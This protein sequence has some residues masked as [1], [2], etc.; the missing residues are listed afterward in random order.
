MKKYKAKKDFKKGESVFMKDLEPSFWDE[1]SLV[2]SLIEYVDLCH[3]DEVL[4]IIRE[5][6]KSKFEQS[7][8][9]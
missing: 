1:E 6:C 7:T 8:K 2:D 9:K 3:I 5:Y 4:E